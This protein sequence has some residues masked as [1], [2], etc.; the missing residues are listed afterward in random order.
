MIAQSEHLVLLMFSAKPEPEDGAPNLSFARLPRL[1][2][3]MVLCQAY[4]DGMQPPEP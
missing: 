1:E 3:A 4:K 2:G